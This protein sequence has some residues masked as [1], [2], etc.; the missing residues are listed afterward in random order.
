MKNYKNLALKVSL[1][2]KR[3]E[4]LYSKVGD[5]FVFILMGFLDIGLGKSRVV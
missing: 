4:T 1:S 5:I 2:T 3:V